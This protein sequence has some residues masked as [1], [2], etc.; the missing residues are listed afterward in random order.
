MESV[1]Q[2][3]AGGRARGREEAEGVEERKRGSAASLSPGKTA[4][5]GETR[6]MC[7]RIAARRRRLCVWHSDDCSSTG[8]TARR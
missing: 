3:E 1:E 4:A 6:L 2:L 5:E 8:G 7:L